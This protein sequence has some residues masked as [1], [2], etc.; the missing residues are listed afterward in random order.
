MLT[1]FYLADSPHVV[2]SCWNWGYALGAG[3]SGIGL[4]HFKDIFNSQV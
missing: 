3:A 2:I 1:Y 4:Q